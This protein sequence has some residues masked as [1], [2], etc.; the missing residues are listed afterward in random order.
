MRSISYLYFKD[1]VNSKI[2]KYI[3]LMQLALTVYA[4]T[5]FGL[6]F[7]P[8]Y[9]F[10]YLEKYIIIITNPWFFFAS[11]IFIILFANIFIY[12]RIE[13]SEF[14][15]LRLNS[16]KSYINIIKNTCILVDCALFLISIVLLFIM[17]NF[18]FSKFEIKIMEPY[19]IPNYIFV[20]FM[21]IKAFLITLMISL[22]NVSLFKLVNIKT[23]I[24][25]NVINFSVLVGSF[26]KPDLIKN[27]TEISFALFDYIKGAKYL[28]FKLEIICFS[29]YMS[30]CFIII[31]LLF[32]I[33]YKFMKKV[34]V[35]EKNFFK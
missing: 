16:Y 4:F 19:N 34:E 25:G 9:N 11:F 14:V 30:I 35:N 33:S 7:D 8:A 15:I 18:T 13:K 27:V 24:L 32:E 26:I 29:I 6:S 17:L 1:F 31:L 2:F 10:N 23:I 28:N 5:S 20:I 12:K 3:F 21:T 22:F